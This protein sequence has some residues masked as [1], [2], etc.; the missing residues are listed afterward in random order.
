MK[1]TLSGH[2][3]LQTAADLLILATTAD[4]KSGAATQLDRHLK[5]ALINEASQQ[6]FKGHE[7]DVAI[8]QTHGSLPCHYVALVGTGKGEGATPWY[9]VAHTIVSRAQEL[10]AT[11]AAIELPAT[12]RVPSVVEWI[13]EGVHLSAYTFDELKTNS[14]RRRPKLGALSLLSTP[15]NG[16]RSALTRGGRRALATC[17][18]RDLINR[19]A[20]LVT[21]SYL[22]EEARK[23][24]RAHDLSVRVLD[25][26]GMK[27]AKMGALL[28]VS[29]G[30]EEP[31]RFI[32]LIYRPS[33]GKAPC[34]VAIAGKGITFDSGGLSLKTS[35]GMQTMKRDMAGGAAVLA[36]MSAVRELAI[37]VEVRGY[38]AAAENMPGGGA[39]KPGDVLRAANGKT[40]EVLNTDAE[41]RLVLADALSYAVAGKPDMVIDFATLTGAVRTALGNRYAAIMGTE[42]KLVDSLIAAGKACGEHFWE[43][44]LVDEYK[45]DIASHIADLKNI[46][47][48]GAGTIIGG[49]FLRE[50]TGKL[51]WAHVDFSSTAHI[52]KPQPCLPRGASGFGVRTLLGFLENAAD[53]N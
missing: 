44:P 13:V 47:E 46:G 38:V 25:E 43:L 11:S 6:A 20:G 19:P 24:A 9:R 8:F 28:G 34:A 7:G 12:F 52:D 22:A 1:I 41:G 51:P 21:P 33:R 36:V 23:L 3:P 5:G 2:S 42:S 45:Q 18:A 29:Q 4:W 40:I 49:L 31:P 10:R 26:R 30:S 14:D 35:E 27:R 15:A 50:F 39:I 48:G 32:E 16:L 17:Y 37:P 53:L